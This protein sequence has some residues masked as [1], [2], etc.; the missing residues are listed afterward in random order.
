M[1]TTAKVL[2]EGDKPIYR[3]AP[4]Y[5]ADGSFFKGTVVGFDP[6]MHWLRVQ[7]TNLDLGI[8][9]IEENFGD[10]LELCQWVKLRIASLESKV[11]T[12]TESPKQGATIKPED[13]VLNDQQRFMLAVQNLARL[14]QRVKLGVLTVDAME[15]TD[16]LALARS[17]YQPGF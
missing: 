16:A 14:D 5:L 9:S 15:Y 4:R 7:F 17:L 11:T 1:E 8:D 13:A 10:K 2:A 3:E 12:K 6:R